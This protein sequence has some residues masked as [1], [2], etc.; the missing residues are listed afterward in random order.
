M[1]G[2]WLSYR[3]VIYMS[4]FLHSERRNS[5]IWRRNS[6]LIYCWHGFRFMI[7]S[8]PILTLSVLPF[9]DML[10]I[11]QLSFLSNYWAMMWIQSIQCSSQTTQAS[12]LYYF[13]QSQTLRPDI[14]CDVICQS[15]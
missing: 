10:A 6:I 13:T 1:K 8:I 7:D 3:N 15:V 5:F 14:R 2:K 11:N 9:R 4:V 12:C